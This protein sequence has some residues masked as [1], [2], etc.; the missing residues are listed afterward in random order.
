MANEIEVGVCA[1]RWSIEKDEPDVYSQL[2]LETFSEAQI[3]S[4]YT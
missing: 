2:G 1:K 3:G 4:Y